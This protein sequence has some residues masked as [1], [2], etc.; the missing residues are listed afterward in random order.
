MIFRRL[1]SKMLHIK[2]Q[3]NS[4]ILQTDTEYLHHAYVSILNNL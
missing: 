2:R 3:N 1:I 4:L